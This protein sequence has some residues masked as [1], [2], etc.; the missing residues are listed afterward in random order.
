LVLVGPEFGQQPWQ[1][2]KALH[3]ADTAA[4]R[5]WLQQQHLHHTLILVKGSRGIGLEKLFDDL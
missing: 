4:A 1:K 5:Q 3:F 2:Y